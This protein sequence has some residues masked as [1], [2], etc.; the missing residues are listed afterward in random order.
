MLLYNTNKKRVGVEPT[1][2]LCDKRIPP[3]NAFQEYATIP[4]CLKGATRTRTGNVPTEK[5]DQKYVGCSA[6]DLSFN[7]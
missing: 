2:T 1:N 6:T 4:S 3:C 7:P 5:V